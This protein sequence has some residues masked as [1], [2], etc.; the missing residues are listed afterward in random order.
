MD[1]PR[2]TFI[3]RLQER[4]LVDQ[5]G[6]AFFAGGG[7]LGIVTAKWL[8]AP[9]LWIAVGAVAVM[10]IYAALISR[11]GS[12]RLRSDQ[13]GDN[14]YYLGLIYTLASLAYAIVTFDP[15]NTATTIV[16]GFGIALA[17]TIVGLVLRVVFNQG[18][19]DLEE[20][21]STAR[22]DLVDAVARLKTEL[23]QA[24]VAMND[25]S[26]QTRQSI[27]ETRESASSD[28]TGFAETAVVGL[29]EVMD[30]A[31]NALQS[32]ASDF[33]ARTKRHGAAVDRLVSSLE[34]HGENL[35]RLASAHEQVAATLG[36]IAGAGSEAREATRTLAEQ[37]EAASSVL[38]A[39]RESSDSVRQSSDALSRAAADVQTSVTKFGEQVSVQVEL[40]RESPG[41]A[42]T[43]A[44][45]ALGR[46]SAAVRDELESLTTTQRNASASITDQAAAAIEAL[47]RHNAAMEAELARSREMVEKVHANLVDMTGELVRQVDKPL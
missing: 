38:A 25:F 26:R 29:R 20:V 5:W 18:R 45:E 10:L 27:S 15:A 4:G 46:A 9:A 11:Y 28:I 47:R 37:A 19:P 31:K 40:L 2:L 3:D 43:A 1:P 42:V 6:F 16:Q 7:A 33:A 44:T 17:T 23:N 41:A 22:R 14:C 24:V 30:A 12:G 39:V 13:A 21:E 8:H 32:E 36:N 35:D 34:A